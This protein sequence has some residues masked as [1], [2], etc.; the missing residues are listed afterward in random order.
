MPAG[1]QLAALC[2]PMDTPEGF[3]DY[4]TDFWRGK[5]VQIVHTLRELAEVRS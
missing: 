5:G 2:T 4:I 1:T 3:A